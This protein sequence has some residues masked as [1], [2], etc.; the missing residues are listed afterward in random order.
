MFFINFISSAIIARILTPDQIGLFSIAAIFVGFA[1]ILRDFGITQY[2]IREP[3][4]N[5]EKLRLSHGLTLLMGWGVALSLLLLS[6]PLAELYD[7]GELTNIVLVLALNFL[8]VPFGS[9]LTAWLRR[10]FQF[11]YMYFVRLTDKIVSVGTAIGLALAGFGAISLAWAAPAGTVAG[12]LI[13]HL[14]R[15]E[16]FPVLP[17]FR[18]VSGIARFSGFTT[19]SS[20]LTEL[21]RGSP[22]LFLGKAAGMEAA[23]LFT[24]AEGIREIFQRLVTSAVHPVAGPLFGKE[25]RDYG[26]RGTLPLFLRAT[27]L[28][29]GIGWPFFTVAAVLMDA[30]VPVIY[31]AQWI[32]SIPIAQVLCIAG[33]V[34]LVTS[35]IPQLLVTNNYTRELFKSQAVSNGIGLLLI[36]IASIFGLLFVAFAVI[37]MQLIRAF[38]LNRVL[39][40][41]LGLSLLDTRTGLVR[42]AVVTVATAGPLVLFQGFGL[43]PEPDL[44]YLA[45]GILLAA[46]AWLLSVALTNHPLWAEIRVYLVPYITSPNRNL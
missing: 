3:D 46:V 27:E 45:C 41:K 42:G 19:G 40:E 33:M 20:I 36:G 32:P 15:P 25:M 39:T 24:R 8:V 38:T 35:L 16:G 29:I 31:G 11:G 26:E 9:V 44:L 7:N 43:L 17:R 34:Q 4:L 6:V 1:H 14:R 18:G 5:E 37:G 22:E 12:I 2:V 23:G 28:M 30:L 21:S 13:L 10:N